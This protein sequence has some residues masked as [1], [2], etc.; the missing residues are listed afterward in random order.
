VAD[1]I[2]RHRKLTSAST[3][4]APPLDPKAGAGPPGVALL[5]VTKIPD[6]KADGSSTT[7]T[8]SIEYTEARR[9]LV[10]AA[11]FSPPPGYRPILSVPSS[12]SARSDSAARIATRKVFARLVDSTPPVPGETRHCSATKP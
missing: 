9:A 12:F 2:K 5:S 10:D 1:V 4:V 3:G 8:L 6:R 11:L 7:L